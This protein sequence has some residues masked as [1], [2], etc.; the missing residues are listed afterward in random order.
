MGE[1]GI[2]L[3]EGLVLGLFFVQRYRFLTINQFARAAGMQRDNASRQLR[4][5]ELRGVLSHFGNACLP[6]HGRTPKVYFLTRRGWELLVRESDIPPELLGSH[7]Q[8]KVDS[9]W[10]PQMYHRLRTVD[11]MISAE[12][13]V[14]RRSRLSMVTTFL[15]YRRVKRGTHLERETTDYVDKEENIYTRIVPDAA[16]ILENIES[17]KRA[18]FFLEM[19]MGTERI[20]TQITRDKRISLFH[21]LSQYDRYLES[22]R[23]RHTYSTF[24]DF[25]FFTLLFITIGE[26]RIENIRRQ[27]QTLPSELSE[28][29]RLTTYERAMGDFFSPIWKSRMLTDTRAYGLVKEAA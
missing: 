23:Y 1:R 28:Y 16:F 12:V 13:A 4:S 6:G 11:L 26:E 21:K 25:R 5:L 17:G 18:L 9:R 22:L 7:T 2:I 20:V 8:V 29:Y 3:T 10:S 15:E 19:D 14:R 24:G 27:M